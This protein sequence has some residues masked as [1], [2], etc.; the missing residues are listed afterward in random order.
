[1]LWSLETTYEH[2]PGEHKD[3]GGSG[4]SPW[5]GTGQSPEGD[6]EYPGSEKGSWV[7]GT[8]GCREPLWG[9]EAVKLSSRKGMESSLQA[10]P[11]CAHSL[12]P[13]YFR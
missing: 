8:E 5:G 2:E 3:S 1:M 10:P 6:Q 4:Y 7:A 11:Q 9:K 13:S 12:T